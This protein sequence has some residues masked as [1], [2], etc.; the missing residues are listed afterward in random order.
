[1]P[2]PRCCVASAAAALLFIPIVVAC[3]AAG[4]RLTGIL[5]SISSAIWFDY[6]L[7]TPYERL[8]ISHRPDLETTICI[9]LVGVLVT[10]LAGRSRHHLEVANEQAAHVAALHHVAELASS[11]SPG[12]AVIDDAVDVLVDLLSLRACRFETQLSRTNVAR[13]EPDG[14]I[15]HGGISW[16]AHEIG[17]PGPQTEILVRWGGVVEGRFLLTP[18]PGQIV[19]QERRMVAVAVADVVGAVLGDLGRTA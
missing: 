18:T 19:S 8:T 12:S 6:F 10:E 16:P 14:H 11:S 9:L 17:I 2:S 7:T 3:G 1:M 5:A 4:N 13:I 15:I